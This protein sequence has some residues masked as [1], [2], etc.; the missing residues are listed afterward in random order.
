MG[1]VFFHPL[2]RGEPAGVGLWFES[3]PH[4][5]QKKDGKSRFFGGDCWIRAAL[6][7]PLAAQ[8]SAILCPSRLRRGEP[9]GVG[10][11][12]ESEPHSPRKK[13]GKSRLFLVFYL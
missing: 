7:S 13:D 12:F 9:A 5:P 2:R 11:R 8:A 6:E 3:E 1:T 10:L 4:S